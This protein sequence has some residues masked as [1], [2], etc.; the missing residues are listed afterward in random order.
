MHPEAAIRAHQDLGA[1][2]LLPV[3]WATFNLAYHEWAEPVLRAQVA[4]TAQGVRLVTPR[5]G[6]TFEFGV[7]FERAGHGIGRGAAMGI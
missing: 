1:T 3:H 6:E 5:V 7:P 2:T 4:A